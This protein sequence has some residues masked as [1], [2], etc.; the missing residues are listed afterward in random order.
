LLAVLVAVGAGWG[1]SAA[2]WGDTL[3]DTTGCLTNG[4]AQV[5]GTPNNANEVGNILVA[6]TGYLKTFAAN[7]AADGNQPVTLALY[8]ANTSGPVGAALWTQPATINS[9]GS[10]SMYALQTF[11]VDQ[12]L[13]TGQTYAFALISGAPAANT[14][15]ANGQPGTTSGACYPGPLIDGYAGMSWFAPLTAR[16]PRSERISRQRRHQRRARHPSPS[17]LSR[18][19]R[20]ETPRRSRSPRRGRSRSRSGSST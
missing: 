20:L 12:P 6:P 17:S 2:A 4:S 7:L 19:A 3:I 16:C 14:W 10:T 5:S 1:G 8:N 11:T 18:R 9:T 13:I 15:W